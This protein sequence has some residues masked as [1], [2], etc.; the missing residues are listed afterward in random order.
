MSWTMPGRPGQEQVADKVVFAITAGPKGLYEVGSH[1]LGI[2]AGFKKKE[3]AWEFTGG[4]SGRS[5]PGSRHGRTSPR[6][7]GSQS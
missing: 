1:A 2:P 7:A 6:P 3:A 5:S 4:P